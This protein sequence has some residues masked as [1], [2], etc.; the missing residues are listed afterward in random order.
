MMTSESDESET[1]VGSNL[2][3]R[4]RK[5]PHVSEWKRN[6]RK[7][8]RAT[9]QTYVSSRNKVVPARNT[10]KDCKCKY[11]CFTKLNKTDKHNVLTKFNAIGDQGGQDKYLAG[12][13]DVQR[14]QRRRCKSGTGKQRSASNVYKI[15]FGKKSFR[16]CKQ[17][18]ASL[19]GISRKRVE[20]IA[21]SLNEDGATTPM[22]DQRGRHH[23]RPNAVPQDVVDK[24]HNHISS[25][26]GR[27]SH[28]SRADNSGRKYLSSELS[29]KKM[30]ALYLKLHE[31]DVYKSVCECDETP[32][33]K[34]V[35]SYDFYF[36][37]FKANFNI[38]F[39]H[40]R[41]DTCQV[42]DSISKE[43][44][45]VTESE[46]KKNIN[47][48]KTLH[49][50]KADSFYSDLRD[51]SKLAK[52][53][54]EIE[55]LSF[56][57]QQNL[58]LP[59]T[60]S[61][62]AFYKRQ[63]WVYNFC[64]SSSKTGKSH[65]YLYDESVGRKTSNEP[66]SFI[67]HYVKHV[68]DPRVKILYLFSDNCVAQNKNRALCQFLFSLVKQGRLEKIV[69][70]Y[71]EPGHSFLPCDRAFGIIEKNVRRRERV[72][73]PSEYVQLIQQSSKKFVVVKVDITFILDFVDHLKVSFL[74]TPKCVSS[75]KDEKFAITKYR[76]FVYDKDLVCVSS[77]IQCSISVNTP[78][79]IN[80]RMMKANS[81]VPTFPNQQHYKG[82]L[83]LKGAK[84]KD[85]M[86]LARKYVGENEMWFYNGLK[87][88]VEHES[89]TQEE[90]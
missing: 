32:I 42:C 83:G 90:D 54:E 40:P 56:D 21:K 9:G 66:I 43:L 61:S 31:P 81:A 1:E 62:D 53:N 68:L 80:V 20:R 5:V 26:R 7:R 39:G 78:I 3:N 72:F 45:S 67:H 12:Q 14:V 74:K 13:I 28:Y 69:H 88:D 35:V 48:R 82:S 10:G 85:V 50:T 4:K 75:A 76:L 36:R 84:Y 89:D 16:V 37:Y 18:F 17:A 27:E 34:P 44:S 71:P 8:L 30:H 57:Y 55:T 11:K 73:L 77:C 29:V 23:N 47:I 87:A 70:R 49:L 52:D 60:P 58:P 64:I 25:F 38:G 41:T 79:F 46:A 86:E 65:F 59:K 6:T 63:C 15:R 19:H 51:K 33:L 22:E 2:N 24:V